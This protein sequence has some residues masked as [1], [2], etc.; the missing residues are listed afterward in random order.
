MAGGPD[1][2][3]NWLL[4][5]CAEFLTSPVCDILNASF[6]EQKLPRTWKDADGLPLMKVKQVTTLAKFIRPISLTP[7]LSKLAEDFVLSKHVGPGVLE[8]IDSNQFG[9]IPKTSTVNALD[10]AYL[11]A[12]H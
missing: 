4:G 6:A 2:I 7:A 8:L 3:N 1:V 9:A 5:E 12:S 11:D 10:A